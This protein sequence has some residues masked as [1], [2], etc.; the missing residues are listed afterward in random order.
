MAGNLVSNAYMQSLLKTV[1]LNGVYNNKYQNSPVLSEIGKESW[2]GG[3]EIK[4]AAQYANGGNFGSN[5]SALVNAPTDGARNIEW[6]M[7][8]GYLTGWF[9]IDQPELLTS[10]SDRGAYMKILNNK[11]AAT[12]DGLSKLLATYLYGGQWGV[13]DQVA[14]DITLS[15]TTHT[16]P[17]TMSGAMKLDLGS[18]FVIATAGSANAA[19]PSSPLLGSGTVFTVTKI[20]KNSIEATTAA[21]VSDTAYAGDYI[22]VFTS[23]NVSTP[24]GPEGLADIIP[25][26]GDRAGND[27]VWQSYISTSFRGVDRSVAEDRLAGQF[28]V[29]AASGATR[30]SDTLSSLLKDTVAAGGVNNIV[31]INNETFDK[32]G[33]E[34]NLQ[35]NLWQAV[36][37][38][39]EKN[40]F[41]AGY[42]ALNTAFGQAFIGRTVIDP[43]CPEDK[44]YMFEKEDLKFYDLGNVSRV[45]NP[46]ANDE[47]GKHDI[48]AV[49]D[50]G[51]GNEITPKLNWDKL[52]NIEQGVPG[53]YGP[54]MRISTNIYG[55]YALRK[56]GS[57]GVAILK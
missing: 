17:L 18:R 15:G 8:Q 40:K 52:F 46:V 34:L 45:I 9:D 50:Q 1:Y 38:G 25:Y 16:F 6:T 56:T 31:V 7:Q 32:I 21:S 44:A 22:E 10:A 27:A 20:R 23:R 55:N 37:S 19:L 24:L 30:L 13:I 57:A 41:T 53:V 47:V 29:A 54:T 35:R 39:E 43:Y 49:G 33:K 26:V 51:I 14:S 5:Y 48:D 36:N 11:M 3:K 4:Y 2:D 12:F 42:S 28:A